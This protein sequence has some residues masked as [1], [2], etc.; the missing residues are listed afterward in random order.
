MH[1]RERMMIREQ[2]RLNAD[3]DFIVITLGDADQ[4]HRIAEPFA[5]AD[6][7]IRNPGNS[8]YLDIVQIDVHREAETG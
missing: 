1:R 3:F 5:E 4:L 2:C 8:F 6:V 7:F